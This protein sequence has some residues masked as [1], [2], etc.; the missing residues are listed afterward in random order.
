MN[1]SLLVRT[2][3][4]ALAFP[5][6]AAA[7][8]TAAPAAPQTATPSGVGATLS[9]T[10]IAVIDIDFIATESAAGK[11][12]FDDLKKEND[13]IAAERARRDQEI[14]DMQTKMGSDI[15]SVDARANLQREIESKQRDA[16]RWIEDQ[17]RAFQE[18]QQA[19]EQKFQE[20]LAPVVEEVARENGIGLIFRTTPGLTFVLDESL[21]ISPLVVQKLN[22]MAAAPPGSN[23]N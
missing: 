16:Q 10:K 22:S 7:Q 9:N 18:K 6:A 8:E 5:L 12:L 11:A 3:S 15:L 20:Q 14:R 19:G 21:D 23:E 17:Q 1:F 4:L 2:A 13:R